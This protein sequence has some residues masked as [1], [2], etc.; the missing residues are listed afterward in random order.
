MFGHSHGMNQLEIVKFL[1]QTSMMKLENVSLRGFSLDHCG[2]GT[3]QS[4]IVFASSMFPY[5]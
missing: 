4:H 5:A 2:Y 1:F 3:V